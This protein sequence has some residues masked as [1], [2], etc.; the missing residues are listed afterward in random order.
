MNQPVIETPVMGIPRE[1]IMRM[2]LAARTLSGVLRQLRERRG[3]AAW[4]DAENAARKNAVGDRHAVKKFSR[5]DADD[6]NAAEKEGR[7]RAER[8]PDTGMTI[9][10]APL[11]G[12]R[13]GVQAGWEDNHAEA[14]FGSEDLADRVAAWLRNNGSAEAVDDLR[15]NVD[16]LHATS[17]PRTYQTRREADLADARKW[18]KDNEPDWYREWELRNTNNG[19]VDGREA[20]EII[21]KWAEATGSSRTVTAVQMARRWLAKHDPEAARDWE[22]AYDNCDTRDGRRSL[23]ADI[24]RL[25]RSKRARQ[26]RN[27][28]SAEP[29]AES[30]EQDSDPQNQHTPTPLADRLRGRVPDRI[31]SDP[32][33]HVAED[34]FAVLTAQ[35]ADPEMLVE[36]VAAIDFNNGQ[37]RAP[38][39]FAAWAMRE[40]AKKGKAANAHTRSEEDARRSVAEEW[41]TAADPESP[42]DRARAAQLVGELGDDFDALLARKYPG[43]LDGDAEQARA[44]AAQHEGTAD[45]AEER[46]RKATVDAGEA[47]V[48]EDAVFVVDSD[49]TVI[50]VSFAAAP[51]PEPRAEAEA[52]AADHSTDARREHEAA[53]DEVHRATRTASAAA[54]A[55]LTPPKQAKTN[56]KTHRRT[57]PPA[58]P[59]AAHTRNRG[60]AH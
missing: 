16:D 52:E 33:W 19:S 6:W 12:G 47:A 32:R 7:I 54:Q 35:G 34:Q 10:V 29:S 22:L 56:T 25:W 5:A 3:R 30:G 39:G 44:R 60:R 15:R 27:D 40:A 28:A 59:A 53:D 38:S 18:A 36:S 1:D 45:A 55:P 9:R 57:P 14:V 51:E 37:I 43:I 8:H 48:D 17:Q 4:E 31:L 13:V 42:F 58:K 23:E 21:Y 24:V 2:A 46:S 11:S 41:L 20:S 26:R 50:T 49:G